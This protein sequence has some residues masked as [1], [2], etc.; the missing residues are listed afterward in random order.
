MSC[1]VS[2]S[3][4]CVLGQKGNS[5]HVYAGSGSVG[6][7]LYDDAAVEARG[8]QVEQGGV[9]RHTNITFTNRLRAID[10]R[11]GDM[12]TNIYKPSN[13]VEDLTDEDGTRKGVNYMSSPQVFFTAHTA[14]PNPFR[15]FDAGAGPCTNPNQG[16]DI[17]EE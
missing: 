8:A 6:S 9:R 12:D 13:D 2:S 1:E 14:S 5:A 16:N 10:D 3:E 7:I 11:L 15:L 4:S 17:D